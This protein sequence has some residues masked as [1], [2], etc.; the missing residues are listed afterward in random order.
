M[1]KKDIDQDKDGEVVAKLKSLEVILVH[2]NP[3]N[4]NYQQASKALFTFLPNSRFG[5]F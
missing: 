1:Q 5:Q 4:N 3:I 2:C